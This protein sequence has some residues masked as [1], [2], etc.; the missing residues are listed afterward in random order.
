MKLFAAFRAMQ[1]FLL[2]IGVNKSFDLEGQPGK[3]SS[4][5]QKVDL[6]KR[7]TSSAALQEQAAPPQL[8]QKLVI[9]LAGSMAKSDAGFAC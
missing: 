8:P 1:L 3:G 2:F 9:T 4:C 5:Q 6:S 7:E